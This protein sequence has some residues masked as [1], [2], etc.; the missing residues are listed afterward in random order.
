MSLFSWTVMTV[1]IFIFV[2]LV[3]FSLQEAVPDTA[4]VIY[5][6]V[7][8]TVLSLALT[9]I[10][11]GLKWYV[12]SSHRMRLRVRDA[13]K[14]ERGADS[15]LSPA[16]QLAVKLYKTC[17]VQRFVAL[18][19]HIAILLDGLVL[20]FQYGFP[21]FVLPYAALALILNVVWF[22]RYRPLVG[23]IKKNWDLYT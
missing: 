11:L 22:P 9:T 1:L 16:D 2:F 10:S 6:I 3:F 15:E 4:N 8:L 7:P 12:T 20:S 18:A 21:Y 14:K 23:K 17:R 13:R 19:L 5:L